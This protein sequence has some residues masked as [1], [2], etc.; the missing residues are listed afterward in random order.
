RPRIPV[1]QVDTRLAC[2]QSVCHQRLGSWLRPKVRREN[3]QWI[4]INASPSRYSPRQRVNNL[5]VT[6]RLLPVEAAERQRHGLLRP[7]MK[8]VAGCSWARSC[9]ELRDRAN[10]LL[11]TGFAARQRLR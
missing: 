2:T 3:D 7:E 1:S 9:P 10:W 6:G 5:D 11:I 4:S 8:G